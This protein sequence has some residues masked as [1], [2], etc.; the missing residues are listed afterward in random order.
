MTTEKK[1]ERRAR[2]IYLAH[3]KLHGWPGW[4][5]TKPPTWAK[6]PDKYKAAFLESARREWIGQDW[7]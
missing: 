3:V 4:N 7:T 2:Q 1:I 5:D 6:L